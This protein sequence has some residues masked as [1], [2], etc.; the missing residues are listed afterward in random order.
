[1]YSP[2]EIADIVYGGSVDPFTILKS[3]LIPIFDKP[4]GTSSLLMQERKVAIKNNNNNNN[5]NGE[6]RRKNN[7]FMC[8]YIY[9]F[10]CTSSIKF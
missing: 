2:L 5:S 1:M 9:I 3:V 4:W 7:I 8:V 6:F 10:Q